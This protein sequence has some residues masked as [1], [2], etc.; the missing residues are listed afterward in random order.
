MIER[1]HGSSQCFSDMDVHM[2]YQRMLL[3]C[4]GYSLRVFVYNK[5][6]SNADA[7]G[8]LTTLQEAKA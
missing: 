2:N 8:L 1:I 4:L 5:F 6:P 7:I 3:K